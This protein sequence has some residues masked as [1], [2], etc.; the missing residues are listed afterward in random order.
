MVLL[1]ALYDLLDEA[2]EAL[3][4]TG[5]VK[6]TH[7]LKQIKDAIAGIAGAGQVYAEQIPDVDVDETVTSTET[8]CVLVN[9]AYAADYTYA[10][11]H[12]RVKCSD[13]GARIVTLKLYEYWNDAFQLMDTFDIDSTNYATYHSLMDMFGLPEVHSDSILIRAVHDGTIETIP[14]ECTYRWAQA[15][16]P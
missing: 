11:R 5:F 8:D 16:K 6:D 15:Y 2:F 3:K 12:L 7:S 9:L 1:K 14:I 10:L 4:G 13:P